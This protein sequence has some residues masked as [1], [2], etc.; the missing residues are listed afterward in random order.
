MNLILFIHASADGHLACSLVL[1]IGNGASVDIGVHVCFE[2][3][4]FPFDEVQLSVLSFP[5]GVLFFLSC[6]RPLCQ[7]RGPRGLLQLF[8]LRCGK[9]CIVYIYIH[10]LHLHWVFHDEFIFLWDTI[11]IP[12]PFYCPWASVLGH[13]RLVYCYG[14]ISA[15]SIC[16]LNSVC[17]YPSSN[18]KL[19]SIEHSH[20][21][22]NLPLLCAFSKLC[23]MFWLL[24]LFFI[25]FRIIS[26]MWAKKQ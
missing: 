22:N 18:A 24:Y 14:S 4:F 2:G 6:G 9:R 7:A 5:F 8:F 3:P 19:P 12:I 25:H 15:F 1:A 16:T 23:L 26:S 21:P 13:P 20:K 10:I 17:L 11:P